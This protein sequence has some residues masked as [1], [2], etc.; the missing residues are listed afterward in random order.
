MDSH[1][2]HACRNTCAMLKELLRKENDILSFY[3]G[4]YA[5]CNYP[6][7]QSFVY[8]MIEEK[9]KNLLLIATKLQDIQSNSRI[10]DGI[11]DSF[12]SY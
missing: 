5:E 6:G 11:I 2:V 1:C 12:D 3:E 4:M 9:K 7:V 8:Q 10:Y